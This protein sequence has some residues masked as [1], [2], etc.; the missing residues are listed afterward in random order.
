MSSFDDLRPRLISAIVMIVLGVGAIWLGG[1]V[2]LALLSVA[3]GVMIWELAR[4][5]APALAAQ[6]TVILGLI[7][8]A[9]ALRVGYNTELVSLAALGLAPVLGLVMIAKGR[10]VFL[11]Y[12]LA[13]LFA[14]AEMFWL[15]QQ[16]GLG[17]VIWLV[18]VVIASDVGGYFFGRILGGPKILPKI[19]P[20]KTWSGTMGG[21]ILA[22]LV[23]LYFVIFAGAEGFLVLFSVLTAIAAQIGDIVESA[24]KRAAAIKDSS[25]LIPGHGGFLD[26]FDALIGAAL[27]LFVITNLT[28]LPKL[29]GF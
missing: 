5:L 3:G 16:S 25:N 10:G 12:G 23:G 21:W 19:S 6:K 15:R 14:V 22:A 11:V 20:K 2:F 24:I 1:W 7:G 9:A 8:G 17:W 4:M 29:G 13:L 28:G 18:A 26:R 27:F